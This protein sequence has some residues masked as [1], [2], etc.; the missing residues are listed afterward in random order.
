MGFKIVFIRIPCWYGR[1]SWICFKK[2]DWIQ[3]DTKS[4]CI[5]DGR[6]PRHGESAALVHGIDS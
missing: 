1:Y 5:V 6:L 2:G 4:F 3:Q